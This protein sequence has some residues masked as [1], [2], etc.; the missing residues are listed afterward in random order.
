M[1]TRKHMITSFY[2]FQSYWTS[3]F[4]MLSSSDTNLLLTIVIAQGRN[5]NRRATT[6]N[7]WR[8][9]EVCSMFRYQRSLLSAFDYKKLV[10]WEQSPLDRGQQ[11]TNPTVGLVT[12]FTQPLTT[13]ESKWSTHQKCDS[14]VLQYATCTTHNITNNS[15]AKSTCA[16]I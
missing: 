8:W 16:F 15:L 12:T 3:Y 13:N 1:I 2:V 10:Y 5:F 7:K 14:S 6:M 11:I 9:L 4:M